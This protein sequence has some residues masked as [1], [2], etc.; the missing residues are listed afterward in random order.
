MHVSA[1][2][3]VK[4]PLEQ[5]ISI[6]RPLVAR[7]HE[8]GI[9]SVVLENVKWAL[10]RGQLHTLRRVHVALVVALNGS[11]DVALSVANLSAIFDMLHE[12]S[13]PRL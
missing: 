2:F 12:L 9:L 4:V 6:I 10:Q 11:S 1:P 7:A 5:R 3:S 8:L 13:I